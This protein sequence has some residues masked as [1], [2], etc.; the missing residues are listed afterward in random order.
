M[1]RVTWKGLSITSK[2][3]DSGNLK[4]KF[5]SLTNGRVE[6]SRSRK[7]KSPVSVSLNSSC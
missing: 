7:A 2:F 3:S 4:H 5:E 1:P 6:R